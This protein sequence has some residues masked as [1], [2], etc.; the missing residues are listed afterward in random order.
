MA[1][2]KIKPFF[3]VVHSTAV[4]EFISIISLAACLQWLSPLRPI[5]SLTRHCGVQSW[6]KSPFISEDKFC[7][8]IVI[9]FQC[10]V[11]VTLCVYSVLVY[12]VLTR[13]WVK[14]DCVRR[15]NNLRLT[16]FSIDLENISLRNA[17]QICGTIFCHRRLTF[18]R[19]G[20]EALNHR[21]FS[22]I[23]GNFHRKFINEAQ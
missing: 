7:S 8:P 23:I 3:Y 4:C 13:P 20:F 21:V 16:T 19:H 5:R 10:T 22:E 12:P 14:C 15:I 6:V 9:N 11:S 17:G 1:R 18:F 2:Y